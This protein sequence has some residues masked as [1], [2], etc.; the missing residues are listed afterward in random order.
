MSTSLNAILK[1]E[2]QVARLFS[3]VVEFLVKGPR[4]RAGRAGS[5]RRTGGGRRLS[6][7]PREPAIIPTSRPSGYPRLS[8]DGSNSLIEMARRRGFRS[9]HTKVERRLSYD[10][11]S[12]QGSR[13]FSQMKLLVSNCHPTAS[14]RDSL[15]GRWAGRG[16]VSWNIWYDQVDPAQL[17]NISMNYKTKQ[18]SVMKGF[19]KC[20]QNNYQE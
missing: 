1:I 2:V 20:N 12:S 15:A 7:S 3:L 13:R 8:L 18:N 6:W 9:F 19:W 16:E 10:N 4:R 5:T 14:G 17:G 11:G